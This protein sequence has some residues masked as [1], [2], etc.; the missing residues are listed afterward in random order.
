MIIGT[1]GHIDHGKT[2]LV[3]ALTGIDADRL[4]EEKARGITIDLGFAYARI[5]GNADA[6]ITGFVDVPGHERFVHTMLAG[7]GGIDFAL[8]VVACDDG[9]MPQTAEHVAILD[10]LGVAR[11]AVALTKAD[12]ADEAQRARVAGEIA[13]LLAGTGLADAP[14]FPVS[15]LT[16]EGVAALRDHLA[17]E[18]RASIARGAGGRMRLVVD[19]SFTLRGAGTVVTGMLVSGTV[20]VGDRVTISPSGITARVRAI[21]A[22]DTETERGEAGQRCALNLAGEGV[23]KEAIARGDVALAPEILAPTDR[24]DA[25]LKVLGSEAKP[26]AGW[27]PAHLHTGAVEVGA[28][29]IPLGEP[30]APGTSGPVQLVLER[31]IAG[32]VGDRYILRD[33]SAR[34]TIGG[35]RF[36]DLRAPARKRRTE[37]RRAILAAADRPEAGAALAALLALPPGVVDHDAFGRDR[38]MTQ[39]EL[40]QAVAGAGAE[41]IGGSLIAK[42]ATA[43]LGEGMAEELGAYHATNPELQGMPRER[44]RLALTP[45]L[46]KEDFLEFLHMEASAGR[47]VLEGAFLRLPSHTARL[48]E[49]DEAVYA[50]VAEGLGGAVRFRPPRVRDFAGTLGLG[51]G[52][53]RRVMRLCARAGRVD[54]IAKDHFFLRAT[55]V[56]MAELAREL[57]GLPTEGWFT[58][59]AFRDR[60]DNGRKVA[61]QILDF[62]DR[63]GLTLRRGDLRRINPRGADLY[64][65]GDHPSSAAGRAGTAPDRKPS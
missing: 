43:R 59:A 17:A 40:A 51:E 12:L 15:A 42:G 37:A 55:T 57:S 52:E 10:L 13:A 46:P 22:Q 14:V 53:I 27:F 26:I 36:L 28:R 7:A 38:A 61:I 35:G 44:L 9:V 32:F 3:K 6:G 33:V 20:T 49:E 58:A 23:T 29:V 2:A 60:M 16:G 11:G 8:I 64:A 39:A 63:H 50:Q 65:P 41:R 21:R 48:T 54:E 47:L 4:A 19:R 1:A 34:R 5:A 45:R 24:I 62:F 56:E 18:E 31:P 30:I 25:A